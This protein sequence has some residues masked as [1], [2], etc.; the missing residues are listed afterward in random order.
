MPRT[1]YSVVVESG[2][3]SPDY[4]RWEER[5]HC[6]H[7]HKSMDAALKCLF[8]L[9]RWYCQHG[10]PVGAACRQCLGGRATANSTSG[11]WY[12]ARIHN[13]NGERV[14]DQNER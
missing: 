9:T 12:G 5:M 11:A 3:C 8:R 14:E 10:R 1:T 4:R 6:G 2:S 7:A 13:Q